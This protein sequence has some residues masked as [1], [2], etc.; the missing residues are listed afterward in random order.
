MGGLRNWSRV[1]SL[2]C[3]GTIEREGQTVNI[4][5]VKKRPNLIRATVT[6]PLPGN[7]EEMLQVIRAHDGRHAWTATRLAGGEELSRGELDEEAAQSLL[8]DAGVLPKLIGMWRSGAE[9]E[10]LEPTEIEGQA[11]FTIRAH[12]KGSEDI[13]TFYLSAEDYRT[14]QYEDESSTGSTMTR[15]EN[16]QSQNGVWLPTLSVIEDEKTGQSI[17]STKSIKVGVGIYPE[18]FEPKSKAITAN[19]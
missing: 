15:L 4:V 5:I 12:P 10:L 8:A 7:D 13:Y 19:L 14:L 6:L 11:A 16:Y 17:M 9:L 2:R 3:C 1:E 18:Y